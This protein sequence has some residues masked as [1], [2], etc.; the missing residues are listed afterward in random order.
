MINTKILKIW[1]SFGVCSFLISLIYIIGF[2]IDSFN[3]VTPY[4]FGFIGGLL[5]IVPTTM[6]VFIDKK[7]NYKKI[8]FLYSLITI[9]IFVF[10][11]LFY[12]FAII[13]L[14]VLICSIINIIY[15]LLLKNDKIK[16]FISSVLGVV[17]LLM[18]VYTLSLYFIKT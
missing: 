2:D 14:L 11:V 18:F 16:L 17:F 13:G 6:V 9:I 15:L 3:K 10:T 12:I 4:L 5:L 7:N 1:E 8:L